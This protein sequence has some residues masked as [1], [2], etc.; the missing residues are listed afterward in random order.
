[1]SQSHPGLH[2]RHLCVQ[3]TQPYSLRKA[4]DGIVWFPKGNSLESTEVPCCQQVGVKH[5]CPLKQCNATIEVASKMA[6]GVTAAR[7][8][9]GVVLPK[10]D[11][12]LSQ[13]GTLLSLLRLISHPTVDLA[14]DMTPSRHAIAGRIVPIELDRLVKQRQGPVDGFPSSLMKL[15]H[16]AQVVVISVE[17]FSVVLR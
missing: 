7:E 2:T 13:S 11:C 10:F 9:D 1:M 12:P 17:D 15:T 16:A 6:K 8:S 5:Q 3:R 4:F 14:P